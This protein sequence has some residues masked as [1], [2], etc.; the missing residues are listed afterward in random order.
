MIIRSRV[1]PVHRKEW[2]RVLDPDRVRQAEAQVLAELAQAPRQGLGTVT[3][4]WETREAG[5][6][7][8]VAS[9]VRR[10][11]LSSTP[12]PAGTIEWTCSAIWREAA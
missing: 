7:G 8:D 3:V 11:W 9:G 6:I 5:P 12:I 2:G 1:H 10:G 4:M